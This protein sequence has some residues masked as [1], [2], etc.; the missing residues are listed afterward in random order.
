MMEFLSVL[1]LALCSSRILFSFRLETRSPKVRIKSVV[2]S[3]RASSSRMASPTDIASGAWITW[4]DIGECG[5][6]HVE[7]LS[8]ER[9]IDRELGRDWHHCKDRSYLL[10]VF[11][12]LVNVGCADDKNLCHVR[13]CEHLQCIFDQRHVAERHEAL[14]FDKIS[15]TRHSVI[16]EYAALLE[17]FRERLA[18]IARHSYLSKWLL[19]K[20][21]PLH[22]R[23]FVADF[24]ACF[25]VAWRL[26]RRTRK[27]ENL[28]SGSINPAS[29]SQLFRFPAVPVKNVLN[30][31]C[32]GVWTSSKDNFLN[33][34]MINHQ[35]S[36]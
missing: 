35:Y 3:C 27:I 31:S 5:E 24:V 34:V 12:D 11:L 9:E 14:V 1:R 18:R 8:I 7:L 29:A 19:G 10:K 25:S 13:N 22:R 36:A 28:Q 30:S 23:C 26:S 6:H 16:A 2:I 33:M 4:T 32:Q 21:L 20:V 15:F 17:V